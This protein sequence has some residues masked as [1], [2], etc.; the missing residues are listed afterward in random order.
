[1][2][3]SPRCLIRQEVHADRRCA[4]PSMGASQCCDDEL[5][6]FEAHAPLSL[7]RSAGILCGKAEQLV[8]CHSGGD[9]NAHHGHRAIDG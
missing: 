6:E 2:R 8:D 9:A 5:N 1:M 7:E 4:P 3:G